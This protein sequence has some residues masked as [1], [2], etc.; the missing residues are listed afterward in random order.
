M[1]SYLVTLIFD[2]V[3]EINGLPGLMVEHFY[4]KFGY[5]SCVGF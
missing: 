5:L 4:V 1:F 3:P 2:F